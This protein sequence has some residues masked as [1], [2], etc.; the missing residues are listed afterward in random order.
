MRKAEMLWIDL[1]TT[2]LLALSEVPLEL[3]LTITDKW[4]AVIGEWKTLIWEAS[5]EYFDALENMIP[6]VRNMHEE[7][8]LLSDLNNFTTRTRQKTSKDAITWLESHGVEKFTLP[9]AGS[10]I[11]SLDRPFA[12]Q[13][14]PTLHEFFHYRNIDVS[15]VRELCKM[16]NPSLWDKMEQSMEGLVQEKH[17]VLEDIQDSLVLYRSLYENFFFLED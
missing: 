12:I 10:S 17:R 1:E 13:H 15:T 3:G 8:G 6:Y 16:H 7:N 14:L 9:M 11:G 4:G 5:P 2:G